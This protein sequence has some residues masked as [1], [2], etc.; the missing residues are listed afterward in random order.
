[1]QLCRC[2]QQIG[3]WC[4]WF[5]SGTHLQQRS[6]W[7]TMHRI[8]P[9]RIN[10]CHYYSSSGSYVP[11]EVRP[12]YTGLLIHKAFCTSLNQ[13][14]CPNFKLSFNDSFWEKY[15]FISQMW[16]KIDKVF[17]LHKMTHSVSMDFKACLLNQP[18]SLQPPTTRHPRLECVSKVNPIHLLLFST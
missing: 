12:I 4:F 10:W 1:M 8:Q 13:R 18:I 2:K 16:V 15:S 9:Q 5:T 7:E 14:K 11:T 6:C 17:A 3:L